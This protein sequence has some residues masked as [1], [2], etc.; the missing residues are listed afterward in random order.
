MQSPFELLWYNPN[1]QP[2]SPEGKLPL[3]IA[4][5][6]HGADLIVKR[7]PR[8]DAHRRVAELMAEPGELPPR[9][10]SCASPDIGH[11]LLERAVV[12]EIPGAPAKV[13]VDLW[14]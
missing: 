5:K 6:E 3:G 2:E 9:V 4:Y 1:L 10:P 8:V 7:Q 11:S 14:R 13:G 12:R